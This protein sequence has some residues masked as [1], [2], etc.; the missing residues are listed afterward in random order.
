MAFL[1][2][3]MKEIKFEDFGNT[4]IQE[5]PMIMSFRDLKTDAYLGSMISLLETQFDRTCSSK[6]E[7]HIILTK[8]IY[9]M[10]YYSVYL[11]M[12]A[13]KL[14]YLDENN[15]ECFIKFHFTS[16][17]G[18]IYQKIFYNLDESIEADSRYDNYRDYT[19]RILDNVDKY[20]GKSYMTLWKDFLSCSEDFFKKSK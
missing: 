9:L 8:S 4:K 1:V 12:P 5:G 17:L 14:F 6:V 13:E 11:D 15:N 3:Y 19:R 20:E 16:A 10:E 7:G 2:F 18:R